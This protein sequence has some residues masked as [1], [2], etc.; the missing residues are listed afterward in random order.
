[1]SIRNQG[2]PEEAAQSEADSNQEADTKVRG[3]CR[4]CFIMFCSRGSSMTSSSPAYVN[5]RF[6]FQS[7]LGNPVTIAMIFPD[8]AI[9]GSP[10]LRSQFPINNEQGNSQGI[11][12]RVYAQRVQAFPMKN[13]SNL[14][15]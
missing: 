2:L 4:E 14:V 3:V 1:M 13:E 5:V 12:P 6:W 15:A 8:L 10:S 7:N 11:C 9:V